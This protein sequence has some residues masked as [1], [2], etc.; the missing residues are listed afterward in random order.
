[1]TDIA[2]KPRR[3]GLSIVERIEYR[4]VVRGACW[5]VDIDK[6]KIYPQIKVGPKKV[7]VHRAYYE[8]TVGPIPGGLVVMHRCDNPRCHR[9]AHLV[10]G[11]IAENVRDA[12]RKGR[13]RG[14]PRLQ[15]DPLMAALAS[16][17]TQ[18]ELAACYGVSQTTISVALRGA[19][20]IRERVVG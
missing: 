12:V 13:H 3:H 15:C 17:L 7:M 16:V 10:L 11:T 8:A 20:A 1:M 4:R 19:G 9:P 5:E 18:H 14:K 2:S 6:A